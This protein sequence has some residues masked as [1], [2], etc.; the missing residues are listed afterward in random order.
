MKKFL[1]FLLTTVFSFNSHSLLAQPI[2][3]DCSTGNVGIGTAPSSYKLKVG[4]SAYFSGG[5]TIP[6]VAHIPNLSGNFCMF[7]GEGAS[8]YIGDYGYYKAIYPGFN[9]TCNL[10]FSNLAFSEIW[11][12]SG[13]ISL[14][15]KRQKENI[16]N[17]SHALEK[18]NK[19]QGV[20]YDFKREVFISDSIKYSSKEIDRL[21]KSRKGQI[22]FLA[23]DVYEVLPEVVVYDDSTDIYGIEYGKVVPL[24]VEAIKE[25]Q[26]QIET[27]KTLLAAQESDIIGL[28]NNGLKSAAIDNT[29]SLQYDGS[30]LY[31]NTPN[32]FN[33][34]TE[35]KYYLTSD[36]TDAFIS[37]CNLNGSQI[38]SIKIDRVGEGNTTIERGTL[39]PGIY[40]YTLVASGQMVDT[41]KM[42]I[43][44]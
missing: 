4:G 19:L 24:L 28:K 38:K 20:N 29:G 18:V 36:A 27:M 7:S 33:Q 10:G 43:T 2:Q 26:L 5:A 41:K 11:C 23:Q 40:L 35:I 13:S 44:E 12:Y 34:S 30:A 14:S 25:Q 22:G 6:N 21:E 9:N 42:M 3:V 39:Q 16:K 17:I 15:D 31:Q 8:L 37:V 1:F 32:P